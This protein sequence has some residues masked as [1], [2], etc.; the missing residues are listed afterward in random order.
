MVVAAVGN[1]HTDGAPTDPVSY[2]AGYPGVIGVGAIGADGQ[3]QAQSQVGDYVA[4]VAPGSAVVAGALPAGLA[5]FTGTSFAAPFV[6]GAAALVLQR[7]PDLTPA[8]V[9]ARLYATADPA[10]DAVPS[11]SYGYGVVN[12]YRAATAAPAAPV[13]DAVR[14]APPAPVP[15]PVRPRPG[16]GSAGRYAAAGGLRW[17]S[18]SWRRWYCPGPPGAAGTPA[19]DPAA[20][21]DPRARKGR[22]GARPHRPS[23]VPD[24]GARTVPS[25]EQLAVGVLG[26]EVVGG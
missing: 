21:T 5:S 8:Q 22:R 24:P 16:L 10:P 18:S 2:P 4:L 17:Y 13:P 9:A 1:D 6:A 15:A 3:R 14:A 20:R 19:A 12:P 26:G 11:R 7:W 23:S 25:A